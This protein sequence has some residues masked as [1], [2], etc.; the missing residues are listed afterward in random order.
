[1]R[2]EAEQNGLRDIE[3]SICCYRKAARADSAAAPIKL[4]YLF[5]EGR[6][7]GRDLVEAYCWYAMAA[8]QS[9]PMVVSNL[10]LLEKALSTAETANAKEKYSFRKQRHSGA[11]EH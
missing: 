9:H 3:Q 7:V 10:A 1:M 11:R 6:S 8:K 2:F 5:A 4:A